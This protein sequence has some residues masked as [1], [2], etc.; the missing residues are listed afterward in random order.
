MSATATTALAAVAGPRPRRSE[1]PDE[2]LA[3]YRASGLT[4]RAFC[5][6][7]GLP[8]S[9]LQWW[10]LRARRRA[11]A[12]RPVLFT[13]LALPIAPPA[14]AP[15]WAVEIVTA[16]GVTVRLR[17]PLRPVVLRTLV[18]RGRC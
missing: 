13:E 16:T 5:A 2:T 12:R 11:E 9:T 6:Q 3:R 14:S 15:A 10:L 4:Q 8:L 18:R 1:S 7:I 17:E